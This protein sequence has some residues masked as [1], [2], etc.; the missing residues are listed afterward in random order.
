LRLRFRL[1][2][3][4]VSKTC[5]SSSNPTAIGLW[6]VPPQIAPALRP[7]PLA[8]ANSHK[9]CGP[10]GSRSSPGL[11]PSESAL[12]PAPACVRLAPHAGLKPAFWSCLGVPVIVEAQLALRFNLPGL[13]FPDGA[14]ACAFASILPVPS[15]P[16]S[17][18]RL[19][20]QLS[21]PALPDLPSGSGHPVPGL[22]PAPLVRPSSLPLLL[23]SGLRP[24]V[25]AP[26][27]PRA[28]S[29]H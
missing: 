16:F 8:A 2:L 15:E 11:R 18:L 6:L 17:K 13:P 1:A 21:R 12:S 24:P 26:A 9:A 19:A 25:S 7:S 27:P 10:P 28:R 4:L 23:P 22:R 14:P 29:A 5:V 20:P 3:V